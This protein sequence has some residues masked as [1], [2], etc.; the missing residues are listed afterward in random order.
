[1]CADKPA[2]LCGRAVSLLPS[3]VLCLHTMPWVHVLIASWS[4]FLGVLRSPV[5]HQLMHEEECN[6]SHGIEPVVSTE[7]V[8]R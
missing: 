7:K 2:R 4:V 5:Q 3:Q 8:C 6:K 1:M